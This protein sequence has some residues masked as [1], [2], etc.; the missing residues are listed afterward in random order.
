MYIGEVL[1]K[2]DCIKQSN[3][4]CGFKLK[5]VRLYKGSLPCRVIVAKDEGTDPGNGDF[6]KLTEADDMGYVITGF[7]DVYPSPY[8]AT[9]N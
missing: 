9:Y 5:V 3:K 2:L 7:A 1:G 8:G 4:L 6:V